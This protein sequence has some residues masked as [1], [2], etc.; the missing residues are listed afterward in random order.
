VSV[1][2]IGAEAPPLPDG[3]QILV[4]NALETLRALPAASV[5]CCVTS[6]PYLWARDYG[7]SPVDWPAV[8][9][10][11][12]AG[13]PPL[14]VPAMRCALGMEP[15]VEAYVAHLVA[16]L[17]EVRR[18]LRDDGTLWLNLGD[19]FC[20]KPNGPN[21]GATRLDG[22]A[23]PHAEYRKLR[24]HRGKPTPGASGLKHKDLC[25][26]PA[27]VALALQA[28]GWHLRL[29]NVWS[30]PNPLPE[31]MKDRPTKAH[32][33]V[34]LLAK[35]RRY[36][37]DVD[38]VREPHV[39]YRAD[40][41][42]RSTMRG[43]AAQK[44]RGRAASADRYYH[45]GGRNK[46]SVWTIAPGGFKGAHFAVMPPEIARIA[47]L[48]GTS[49]HGC[50]AACGAPWRRIVERV[51]P[52]PTARGLRL[53]SAHVRKH[54]SSGGTSATTLGAGV[55]RVPRVQYIMRGWRAPCCC[56]AG[57]PV[58]AVVL[59]VCAGSGTTLAV[60]HALGRHAI[61]C[62]LQ[63]DYVPLI[64]Q[65]VADARAHANGLARPAP[66]AAPALQPSLFGGD[67][68]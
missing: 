7:S 33:F 49:E 43:Q 42:G 31:S 29:D 38:A 19:T 27:R 54:T 1:E 9:Y 28:D 48:A 52:P 2:P 22:S 10:A 55:G 64:H 47:V 30:K 23:R 35:A 3:V 20:T 11:P 39:D 24:A 63:S 46:R 34:Y 14:Q 68:P 57:A 13:L 61:G 4:G 37:Y 62:E 25:M 12:L 6:P 8:A 32:E 45:P 59:D 53:V 5:H 17:R 67:Q 40:K 60:A 56:E 36:F 50:C 41:A 21:V 16:L 51:A 58:P 44:P 65:H 15:T 66:L 18:V 26:A